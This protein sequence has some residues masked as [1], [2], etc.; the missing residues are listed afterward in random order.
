[1]PPKPLTVTA[2]RARLDIFMTK[3]KLTSLL[4]LQKTQL[5]LKSKSKQP[6]TS[7][8]E[9]R[10]LCVEVRNEKRSDPNQQLSYPRFHECLT[11]EYIH[12]ASLIELSTETTVHLASLDDMTKKNVL[13][14]FVTEPIF[15]LWMFMLQ[16]IYE[17]PKLLLDIEDAAGEHVNLVKN[18]FDVFIMSCIDLDLQ[19]SKLTAESLHAHDVRMGTGL[20]NVLV[21]M[22]DRKVLQRVEEDS[23]SNI[24]VEI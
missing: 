4:V 3:L 18:S 20:N 17:H 15:K 2:T 1:M 6:M 5:I 23:E 21:G 14:Q 10:A 9:V 8:H 13:N 22:N 12:Y 19:Q 11:R 7:S 24:R 16:L